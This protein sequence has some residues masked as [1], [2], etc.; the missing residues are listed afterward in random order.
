MSFEHSFDSD[1]Y[2][3][4]TEQSNTKKPTSV[5]NA[6]FNMPKKQYNQMCK[7]IFNCKYVDLD[8]VF[9]KIMETNTV[10]NLNSPVEVYIDPKGY[11]SIM[12][13]DE[14][15]KQKHRRLFK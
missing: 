13:W 7:E 5:Y 14:D 6:L 1:F 10:G 9:E 15:N 8:V 2:I 3:N 12:V 11:Y 4:G